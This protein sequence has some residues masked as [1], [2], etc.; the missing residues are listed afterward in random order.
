MEQD[1]E[2]DKVLIEKLHSQPTKEEE[3]VQKEKAKREEE[4]KESQFKKFLEE[5]GLNKVLADIMVYFYENVDK[6]EDPIAFIRN[7]LST[8]NGQ[9]IEIIKKE[10]EE[11]KAKIEEAK[12]KLA[13]LR[14]QLETEQ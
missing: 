2:L 3:K 9:D 4:M 12:T 6:P 10:N 7:K 11:I 14:S 13:N 8:L 5:K 1:A